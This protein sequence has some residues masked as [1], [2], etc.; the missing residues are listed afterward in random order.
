MTD[1]ELNAATRVSTEADEIARLTE[2]FSGPNIR[3][4]REIASLPR[5][6]DGCEFFLDVGANIGQYSVAA[7]RCLSNAHILAIEA[8]PRFEPAIVDLVSRSIA[9]HP[10]GNSLEVAVAAVLDEARPVSFFVTPAATT[11]SLFATPGSV[12]ISVAG[13]RLDDFFRPT[14][15]TVVKMDIEGA[16]YRALLGAGRFLESDHCEFLMELHGWGDRSIRKY[17]IHILNLFYARGYA[18]RKVGT[19]YHFFRARRRTRTLAYLREAPFLLAQWC[20]HR[21]APGLVPWVRRVRTA[22]H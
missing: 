8:N 9:E 2:E 22:L 6:L 17:P 11:S 13:R 7:N 19:H 18:A 16:E 12:E 4:A 10:R 20:V 15:K 14:S 5:L 3:E 1:T 21:F